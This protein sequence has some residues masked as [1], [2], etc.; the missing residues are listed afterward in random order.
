MPSVRQ[1]KPASEADG[2]QLITAGN[3]GER[4]GKS[5]GWLKPEL[6]Q[7]LKGVLLFRLCDR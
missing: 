6:H 5:W 2:V 7:K 4:L 1:L 3:Y